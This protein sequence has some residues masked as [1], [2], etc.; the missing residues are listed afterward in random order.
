M[1]DRNVE[2]GFEMLA[3]SKTA[4]REKTIDMSEHS[5]EKSE[6]AP[7][8]RRSFAFQLTRKTA[9]FETNLAVVFPQNVHRADQPVFMC[10]IKFNRR[11]VAQSGNSDERHIVVMNY[12]IFVILK[13]HPDFTFER[14]K[15]ELL[16]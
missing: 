3:E 1:S 6:P 10:S 4:R 14:R 7:Q 8:L 9:F 11:P 16:R 5:L 15:P 12:V 2:S 13:R